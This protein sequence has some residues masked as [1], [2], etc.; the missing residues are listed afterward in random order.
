M[1]SFS[2]ANSHIA[3]TSSTNSLAW[4]NH[5]LHQA[6]WMLTHFYRKW[7]KTRTLWHGRHIKMS[8]S[9][10]ERTM[11]TGW[12][13]QKPNTV[14]MVCMHTLKRKTA[15]S[16]RPTNS[17]IFGRHYEQDGWNWLSTRW[18]QIPGARP[19]RV[20]GNSYIWPWRKNTQSS[21]LPRMDGNL[22]I[23][24]H[25]HTH[26]GAFTTWMLMG[27][28]RRTCA[29]LSRKRHLTRTRTSK[30]TSP[31]LRSARGMR[32]P[33]GCQAK[34]TKVSRIMRS[35]LLIGR[36]A[37]VGNMPDA[38]ESIARG[39]GQSSNPSSHSDTVEVTMP[40]L[41]VLYLILLLIPP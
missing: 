17:W 8:I 32:I 35:C 9:G 14:I 39:C 34:N 16:L 13:P 7:T 23:F 38:H 36:A 29:T 24:A 28:W 1:S 6:L 40:G 33:H 12:T 37:T 2:V 25:I 41:N 19:A 31:S 4:S 21:S 30:T 18:L 11:T 5:H 20:P 10:Q 15:K 26:P 22:K 27:T 3:G